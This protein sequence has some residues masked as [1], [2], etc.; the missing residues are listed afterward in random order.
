MKNMIYIAGF[1][2]DDNASEILYDKPFTDETLASDWEIT[3]GEWSV[4]NGELTGLFRGNGGG[5][6]YT[7]SSYEGDILV[8]F[9]GHTI[10]PCAND[11][12][13]SWRT[14]GWDYKKNDAARGYI[15]GL[16]GWWSNK[17]GIERYPD[18]LPRSLTPLFPLEAGRDYFIQFGSIGGISFIFA[19]GK[20]IIEM[21]DEG[22]K[23]LEH[24]GRVGLGTYCSHVSFRD[25]KIKRPVFKPYRQSYTAEF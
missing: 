10:P 7:N 1:E 8:E 25:F 21:A 13:F 22:W 15:G 12:N 23:A 17:T 6:V 4:S 14:D 18:C 5:L 16:G 2:I 19:D 11:L 9:R 3:G 24:C 20:L